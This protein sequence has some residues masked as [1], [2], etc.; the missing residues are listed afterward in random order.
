CI[1]E[2]AEIDEWVVETEEPEK[3]QERKRQKR[4][5]NEHRQLTERRTEVRRTRHAGIA[6]ARRIERRE[7]MVL[8][9]VVGAAPERTDRRVNDERREPEHRQQRAE[10]PTVDTQCPR[11]HLGPPARPYPGGG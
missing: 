1:P 3:Q 7:I 5:R 6:Q 8:L 9:D 10:P 4:Q 11:H 2:R